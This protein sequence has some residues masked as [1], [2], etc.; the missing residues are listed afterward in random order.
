MKRGQHVF[1]IAGL[2]PSIH[3]PRSMDRRVK[4]GGDEGKEGL[5]L[6]PQRRE[7]ERAVKQARDQLER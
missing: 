5:K 4:P 1:V 7:I 2:D 6:P 3:G